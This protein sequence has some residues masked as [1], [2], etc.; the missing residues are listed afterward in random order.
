MAS[1]AF[2]KLNAFVEAVAEKK[3]DL[4]SDTLTLALCSAA[5]AP[6]ATDAVLADLTTIAY[7]NLSTRVLAQS[8]SVQAS[9]TYKLT[10][11]DLVLSASGGDVAAF[12]YVLIYN[13]TAT[14]DELIGY[15][16]YGVDL[17]LEDGE[18]LTVD[19]DG[20]NGVLTLA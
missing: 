19:F 12:R 5:N 15:Y 20:A 10:I 2:N 18:S 7:T 8:G 4:G 13:D 11:A 16:D 14:S 6:V 9:G 1:S 17:V 3:H